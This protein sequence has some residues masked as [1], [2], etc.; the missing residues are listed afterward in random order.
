VVGDLPVALAALAGSATGLAPHCGQ[1]LVVF[2]SQ[3]FPQMGQL[4]GFLTTVLCMVRS[5][6]SSHQY[7]PYPYLT[8]SN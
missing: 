4:F 2:G 3:L 6:I 1:C 5:P 7:R 8:A